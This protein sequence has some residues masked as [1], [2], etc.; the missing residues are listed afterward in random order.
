MHKIVDFACQ[1]ECQKKKKKKKSKK[2]SKAKEGVSPSKKTECG[3]E[4]EE[5]AT[6][7]PSPGAEHDADTN[8][9]KLTASSSAS[10]S[11]SVSASASTTST[12]AEPEMLP[13]EAT[14]HRSNSVTL[15]QTSAEVRAKL[16]RLAAS[17][18]GE[19]VLF[20][21]PFGQV[22]I[23]YADFTGSG[24]FVST[25]E[26]WLLRFALPFYSNTHTETS[27]CG[28]FTGELREDARNVIR[29]LA[30]ATDLDA[31]VFTGFGATSA[32]AKIIDVLQL[33]SNA[34][35]E[36]RFKVS[37]RLKPEDRPLVLIGPYEHHSNIILW[38]E[39]LADVVTVRSSIEGT[40][41]IAHLEEL[42]QKY[43]KRPMIIGSFSAGSNVTG[44]L[45]NTRELS[46]ILHR[47]G[48]LAFF[49]F[50]G[51]GP[52]ASL[53]MNGSSDV[54][55]RF[56]HLD[57]KDA[58]FL[59]PH[60]FV[61]GPGSP[62]L[63]IVK[64]KLFQGNCPTVPGG[65]TVSYVNQT[66]HWFVEDIEA[67]EEGGT[68]SIIGVMRAA[69]AFQIKCEIG[70]DNIRNLEFRYVHRAMKTW[71]KNPNIVVLG[72]T[73]V[74]RLAILSMV[75]R[76]GSTFLHYDFVVALLNDLYGIQA[77]GGCACAAPYG[78][79]LLG[80]TDKSSDDLHQSI[81]K[82]YI[83]LKPGWFRVTLAYFLSLHSLDYI[84]RAVDMIA[85]HGHRLLPYYNFDPKTGRW[86]HPRFRFDSRFPRFSDSILSSTPPSPS[87]LG[88]ALKTATEDELDRYAE[89]ALDIMLNPERYHKPG[90]LGISEPIVDPAVEKLRWF[91]T[92][93]SQG[94][95]RVVVPYTVPY[96][97]DT[98]QNCRVR[99]KTHT[100]AE[101]YLQVWQSTV[102]RYPQLT[103]LT[104]CGWLLKSMDSHG[105][106]RLSHK[107]RWRPRWVVVSGFKIAL[108]K[109]PPSTSAHSSAALG[110]KH[111][112]PNTYNLHNMSV[113]WRSPSR[114]PT[115]ELHLEKGCAPILLRSTVQ[116]ASVP[117]SSAPQPQQS[118]YA[119]STTSSA[120]SSPPPLSSSPPPSSSSSSSSSTAP[121]SS[122]SASFA[123][124]SSLL[125][126]AAT[127]ATPVKTTPT[128]LS[129]AASSSAFSLS[130]NAITSAQNRK[131]LVTSR[132]DPE[133]EK[134]YEFFQQ[135]CVARAAAAQGASPNMPASPE[136]A[137]SS[138][139]ASPRGEL[140]SDV[141][142]DES[143]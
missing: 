143:D 70:E 47:Y 25:I 58:V 19:R 30:G 97:L 130:T 67:R 139:P 27:S 69:L 99:H 49:D 118:S 44:I 63:L 18:I 121:L 105:L 53:H 31:V 11:A 115:I 106:G 56:S 41:D 13:F 117:A 86:H 91:C 73:N 65:G 84:I 136:L 102:P 140:S 8:T 36:K 112:F 61:G 23:V 10:A 131:A 78:H 24:R 123:T 79:L 104:H 52:Y 48:A 82:G 71:S 16:D 126:L 100:A 62:G 1:P 35:L 42:L 6:K 127:T 98:D 128:A 111:E 113:R 12:A 103:D 87:G 59:S 39:S 116:S 20:E 75:I 109:T 7:T 3:A 66:T 2:K 21:G 125:S 85:T 95:S 43:R 108:Y 92:V 138:A 124:S 129:A 74:P 94:N 80:L 50:A 88:C 122:A 119:S 133:L 68:P 55:D 142:S 107:H 51:A 57:Y 110:G 137:A 14:A 54:S 135:L 33:K 45:T 64:K 9:T 96:R 72:D 40:P 32:L 76:C 38:R 17:V 28:L 134:W 141:D 4:N 93:H 81:L 34:R 26:N 89:R 60:K 90:E 77:R 83:G 101:H 5:A 114:R 46:I 22:P 120:S 37:K 29:N 15:R 132:V